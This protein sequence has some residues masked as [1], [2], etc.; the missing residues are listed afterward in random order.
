MAEEE[1]RESEGVVARGM[2]R[3]DGLGRAMCRVSSSSV[4]L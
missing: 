2:A 1:E 3:E 4:V